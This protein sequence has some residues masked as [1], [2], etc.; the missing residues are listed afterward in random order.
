M[1]LFNFE[2]PELGLDDALSCWCIDYFSGSQNS[3]YILAFQ[4]LVYF[5][6]LLGHRL[7]FKISGHNI[8]RLITSVACYYQKMIILGAIVVH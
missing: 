8:F 2:G 7:F 3:E 4:I 5:S 1:G 6:D